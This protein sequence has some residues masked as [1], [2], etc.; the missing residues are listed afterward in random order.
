LVAEGE[1]VLLREF[2]QPPA[3]FPG[4]VAD[5]KRCSLDRLQVVELNRPPALL[6]LVDGAL[7]RLRHEGLVD[8]IGEQVG[9]VVE[10]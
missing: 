10:Y 8:A 9:H 1:S 2:A 4:H 5:Q 3:Q 7:E 6:N